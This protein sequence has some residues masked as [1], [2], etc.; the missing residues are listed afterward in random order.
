MTVKLWLT[1]LFSLFFFQSMAKAET[2]YTTV[3]NVF[4]SIKSEK[5]LVLSGIDGR[6]YKTHNG[7]ENLERLASM[8][9]QVVK[10][11]YRMNGEEA[12]ITNIRI[13]FANEVDRKTLDLNHFQY[14]QLRTFAPTDLKNYDEALK[15]FN[16][17]LNDG[18]KG[19]SQCFQRA[20]MWSFDMWSKLNI[21]SQKIFVFYTKRYQILEEWN[22]WFHVAPMVTAGGVDYVM[23]GTFMKKPTEVKEWLNYFLRTDKITCPE[24]TTYQEF[25]NGHW[26]RLCYVMKVP[27]YY[28]RPLDMENR[29]KNGELRN[30]WILE[31]LQFARKA[32]K[33]WKE[34][35]EGLDT[36]KRD[37]KF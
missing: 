37:R 10:L 34:T 20:H 26:K 1:L 35:Y 31:E 22:W 5:L 15:V 12:I 11:D 17:M 3:F 28:L 25:E 6:V 23:D 27:M 13:A 16:N 4:E 8:V 24:I 30:H 32:F 14:D 18:D 19:W 29:D 21:F 9:G 2:V 36:G 33:N 7:E